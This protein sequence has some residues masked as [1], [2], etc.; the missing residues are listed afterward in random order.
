AGIEQS[1]YWSRASSTATSTLENDAVVLAS[2]TLSNDASYSVG[3]STWGVMGTS[4]ITGTSTRF[5]SSVRS[6]TS[7]GAFNNLRRT[8]A[9]QF[10]FVTF[11]R[12]IAPKCDSAHLDLC[13]NE[14]Q[15]E[16][17]GAGFWYT[18]SN[19]EICSST[20]PII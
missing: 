4:S 17:I 20:P 6:F 8:V 1:L 3:Y 2:S 12:I 7:A 18:Y 13:F 14:T 11:E 9:A 16:S 5:G 15:C 10:G 19:V